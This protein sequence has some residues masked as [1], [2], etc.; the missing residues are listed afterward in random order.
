MSVKFENFHTLR[1]HN[2]SGEDE[3]P[4]YRRF[5]EVQVPT[6]PNDVDRVGKP[7]IKTKR[8]WGAAIAA[9]GSVVTILGY[10]GVIPPGLEGPITALLGTIV[11][12]VGGA[13]ATEPIR[14]FLT[15]PTPVKR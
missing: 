10:T 6:P 15:G 14:G 5:G 3:V 4:P 1:N 11:G 13:T 9:V 8:F 7:A 2:M 12:Y